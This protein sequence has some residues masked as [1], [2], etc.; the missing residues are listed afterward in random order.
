M[1]MLKKSWSYLRQ[2]YIREKKLKP[3]GSEGGKLKE[4]IHLKHLTF[5]NSVLEINKGYVICRILIYLFLICC[6]LNFSTS[7]NLDNDTIDDS[8]NIEPKL[9][10][11]KSKFHL[12]KNTKHYYCLLSV[13]TMDKYILIRDHDT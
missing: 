9:K 13:M 4:W 3:S 5:L 12:K 10:R 2:K 7:S 1:E 6:V 11:K 8:C